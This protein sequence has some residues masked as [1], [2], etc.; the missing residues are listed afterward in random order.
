MRRQILAGLLA[1]KSRLRKPPRQ[2]GALRPVADHDLG[3]RQ[4][5]RQKRFEV[6]F[7]SDASDRHED[8]PGQIELGGIAGVEQFG[9]DATRP[10]AEL[11]ESAREQLLLQRVGGDHG[12]GGRVMEVAQH[13]VTDARGNAGADRNIFGKSRRVGRR[14]SEPA[15]AAIAAHRPA[16]RAFRCDVNGLR[17]G[18]FDPPGDLAPVRQ[19]HAQA[20][21]GRH[22]ERGKSVGR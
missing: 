20:G 15:A 12:H 21:I 14:E 2:L 8:R 6:L 18:G 22:T 3:P 10:E 7:H 4:I 5:Q 1:E 17:R 16:D 13:R 11:L 19:R 9:I